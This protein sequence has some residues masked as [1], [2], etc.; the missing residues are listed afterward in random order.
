MTGGVVWLLLGKVLVSE[1]IDRAYISYMLKEHMND[2]AEF[3]HS[4]MER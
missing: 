3:E 2:V 1:A 4:A